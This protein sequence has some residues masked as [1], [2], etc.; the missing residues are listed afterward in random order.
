MI[1]PGSAA[2]ANCQIP[3]LP[4]PEAPAFYERLCAEQTNSASAL[5]FLILTSARTNEVR[6]ATYD[7]IE[8]GIW[9]LSAERTKSGLERRIPLAAE[10]LRVIDEAYKTGDRDTNKR[11]LFPSPKERAMSDAI[12]SRW[13]A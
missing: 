10:A 2:A 4:Y 8:D 11:L 3:S 7:E 6:F 1:A 9:T 13:M 12:M 5:R